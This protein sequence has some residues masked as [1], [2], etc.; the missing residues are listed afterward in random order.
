MISQHLK[1]EQVIHKYYKD[2]GG[3]HHSEKN[4]NEIKESLTEE[5]YNKNPAIIFGNE[6]IVSD[7][8]H[9]LSILKHKF[10]KTKS[11]AI[12]RFN[13]LPEYVGYRIS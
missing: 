7:G 8:T 2:F 3:P 6:N 5:S 9:R 11:V 10:P 12:L 1:Q 13:F 4:L